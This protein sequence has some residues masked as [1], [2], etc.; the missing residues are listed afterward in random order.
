MVSKFKE[1]GRG[2]G[3]RDGMKIIVVEFVSYVNV[4]S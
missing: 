2:E 1:G 3:L 4:R